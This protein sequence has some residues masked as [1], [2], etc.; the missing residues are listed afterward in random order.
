MSCA[1]CQDL[2]LEYAAGALSGAEAEAVRAHLRGGRC[3]GCVGALAEA[4]AVA[5]ELPLA[6]APV[7]PP[8]RARRALLEQIAAER[9][10]R[11]AALRIDAP[12][13]GR[14]TR[15]LAVLSG[16]AALFVAG[17]LLTLWVDIGS[18]GELA[19]A[20]AATD[21]A[22]RDLASSRAEAADL[23]AAAEQTAN[24]STAAASQLATAQQA[25]AAS[26][27]AREKDAKDAA[28]TVA[29][30]AE[31]REQVRS[32]RFAVADRQRMAATLK[33]RD[34]Q[35]A[36]LQAS[37]KR[38]E[39]RAESLEATVK[40]A[41]ELVRT[42]QSKN[43]VFA[44]LPGTADEPAAKGRL[45]LDPGA[46]TWYFAADGLPPLPAERTYEFWLIPKEGKGAGP[47]PAGLFGADAQGRAFL[48]G[49]VPANVGD[50]AQ[51]AVTVEPAAGSAAPTMPLRL[52]GSLGG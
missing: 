38:L 49:A 46:E 19:D 39:N 15:P 26:R 18:S 23:R 41:E 47:V 29:A 3:V 45:L 14:W 31:A 32:L 22:K 13:R 17:A 1:E 11:S 30:L 43:L 48:T 7:E 33:E 35:V 42:L 8:A 16:L 4:E 10:A 44:S 25:L 34:G 20:R 36:T 50:F 37:V 21:A 5:A 2:I 40:A 27:A 9:E 12:A 24:Q 51:A 6:L 52:A 28:G